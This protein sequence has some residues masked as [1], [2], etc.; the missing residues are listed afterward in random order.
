MHLPPFP[1]S[2]RRVGGL[3]AALVG[4]WSATRWE[5]TSRDDTARRTDV[6]CDLDGTITLS[7]SDSAWILVAVVP[8]LGSHTIGGTY[9]MRGESIELAAAVGGVEQVVR[10]RVSGELLSLRSEASAW[11][12]GG[13]HDEPASL[14]AVFVRL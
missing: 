1:E 4:A 3:R 5:Y 10:F 12:F 7:L 11:T 6:V 9:D 13:G 14:I 8:G 2:A